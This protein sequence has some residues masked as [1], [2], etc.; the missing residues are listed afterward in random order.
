MTDPSRLPGDL[1]LARLGC[2][3]LLRML[4]TVSEL[5][6][7]DMMLGIV[8]VAISQAS[9][10]HLGL[11]QHH[12]PNAERVVLNERRRPVTVLSVAESLNLPRET[13]R[14]HVAKL[15]E[16]GY[17]A[18]VQ[19]RRVIVPATVYDEPRFALAIDHTRRDLQVL[20]NSIRRAG[21]FSDDVELARR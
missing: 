20:V 1:F 7:G 16:R 2:N 10:D 18:Q 3:H 11:T 12:D 9:T 8:F 13:V 4:S 19:G 15:I 14:R 21:L 6:D 5:F 17:C